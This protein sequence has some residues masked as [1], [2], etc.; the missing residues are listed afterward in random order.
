MI[1][2]IFIGLHVFEYLFSPMIPVYNMSSRFYDRLIQIPVMLILSYMIIRTFADAYNESSKTL[3]HYANYDMLTGLLNRWALRD[4]LKNKF[5]SSKY[6]GYLVL[7]DIDNFKLVNDNKGHKIGDDVLRQF[8]VVLKRYFDNNQNL[9]CRWGGD[10]F[11]I[12]F[13]DTSEKLDSMIEKARDDF[14][15]YSGNIESLVDI[16]VGITSLE[17]CMS[18]EDAFIKSD[19]LMYKQK[20]SKKN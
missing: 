9:I 4:L 12:F 3:F 8:G 20:C 16:S 2:L 19:Q 6:E 10:E 5:D 13:F 15:S 17:G 14:L 1:V 11:V 18:V 7:L